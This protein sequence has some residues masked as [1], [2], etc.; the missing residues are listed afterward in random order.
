MIFAGTPA[1]IALSGISFVTTALA[2]IVTLLPIVTEPIILH[3]MPKRQLSPTITDSSPF[4]LFPKTVP[5]VIWQFFPNFTF[6]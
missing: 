3:E 2:P 6:G 1:T 4:P 5:T